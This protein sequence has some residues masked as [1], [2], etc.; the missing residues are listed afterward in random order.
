MDLMDLDQAGCCVQAPAMMDLPPKLFLSG[1]LD[2]PPH[3][4]GEAIPG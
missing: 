1:V 2:L 3:P 4:G